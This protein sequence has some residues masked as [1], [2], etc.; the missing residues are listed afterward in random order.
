[1]IAIAYIL[2]QSFASLSEASEASVSEVSLDDFLP[3]KYDESSLDEIASENPASGH[4]LSVEDLEP[5]DEVVKN[6]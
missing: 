4:L 3:E 5:A 1:M 6:V 2:F